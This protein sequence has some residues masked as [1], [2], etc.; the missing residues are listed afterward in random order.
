M[1]RI[2]Q[3]HSGSLGT[4]LLS[5]LEERCGRINHT[6]GRCVVHGVVDGL[7]TWSRDW[8]QAATKLLLKWMACCNAAICN[9]WGISLKWQYVVC[10]LYGCGHGR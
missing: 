4:H 5:H 10:H 7:V 8:H 2:L 1:A 3:L 6:Y 9:V